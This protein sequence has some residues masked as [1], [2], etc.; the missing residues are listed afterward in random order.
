[1]EFFRQEYWGGLPCSSSRE[2]SQSRDQTHVSRVSCIGRWVLHHQSHLGSSIQPITHTQLW[3]HPRRT[4]ECWRIQW[5]VFKDQVWKWLLV[6][7]SITHWSNP[8][9]MVS[10]PTAREAG[11]CGEAR[12]Y[13]MSIHSVFCDLPDQESRLHFSGSGKAQ[14]MGRQTEMGV[15]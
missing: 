15:T 9:C 14:S 1:M 6:L 10:R 13:L 5:D 7:L 4:G 3:S 2:F 11:K 12:G 8:G